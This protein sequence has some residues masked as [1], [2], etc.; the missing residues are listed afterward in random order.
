MLKFWN[1]SLLNRLKAEFNDV[2]CDLWYFYDTSCKINE[3]VSFLYCAVYQMFIRISYWIMILWYIFQKKT[4]M[5]K[6]LF[7]DFVFWLFGAM[8]WYLC[9]LCVSGNSKSSKT[10]FFARILWL[11]MKGIILRNAQL[12]AC[13]VNILRIFFL[14]LK[15]FSY[16][17]KRIHLLYNNVWQRKM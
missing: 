2:S 17:C 5:R 16:F 13:S 6:Q 12:F 14:F 10:T 8:K 1:F 4:F 3:K 11:S 9:Y 7:S 15:L